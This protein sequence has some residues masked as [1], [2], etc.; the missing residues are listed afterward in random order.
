MVGDYVTENFDQVDL[1]G[2]GRIS[3]VLFMGEQ[4]NNEAIYRTK[5]SVENANKKLTAAS[6]NELVF[7]DSG[8]TDGYLLDKEGKWSAQ[9]ANEYMTTALTSYNAANDNMIE[10]IICNN[11]NMAEGAITALQTAGFNTGVE[12]ATT[13][14]VFGVDATD[15]AKELIKAGKMAGTIKQDADGMAAALLDGMGDYTI[16]EN[17]AKVRIPYGI[18]LG[19][20]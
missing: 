12:G 7:Y 9:A 17:T 16:D 6:Q 2:D 20:E 5:Y 1:N 15:A 18:Y 14:P 4:G 19:E 3:Y 10:L 13:I 11:D 8:N